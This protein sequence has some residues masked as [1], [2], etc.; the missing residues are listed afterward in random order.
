MTARNNIIQFTGSNNGSN[1]TASRMQ[2]AAQLVED[3]AFDLAEKIDAQQAGKLIS[4]SRE[5][6]LMAKA[7]P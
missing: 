1:S 7:T 5:L 4:F 2:Q 6:S 3:L